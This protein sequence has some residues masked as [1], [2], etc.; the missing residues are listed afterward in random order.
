MAD[1]RK[2]NEKKIF[3][4]KSYGSAQLMFFNVE[5]DL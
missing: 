2:D 4:T 1:R 5:T 3:D